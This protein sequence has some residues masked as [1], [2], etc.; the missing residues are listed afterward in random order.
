MDAELVRHVARLARIALAEGETEAQV[1][2]FDRLLA[3]VSVLE[4]AALDGVEPMHH[5]LDL[6]QPLR[7]DEA[8]PVPGDEA[9]LALAPDSEAGL[10]LVP[11]VIE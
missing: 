1:E 7:A 11:K 8:A 2:H 5:P 10:F 4:R 6:A 9:L 3:M